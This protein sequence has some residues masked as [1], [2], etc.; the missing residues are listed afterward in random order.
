MHL[1]IAGKMYLDMKG[2]APIFI[3][4]GLS[5]YVEILEIYIGNFE[6]AISALKYL[7]LLLFLVIHLLG[8]SCVFDDIVGV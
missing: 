8:N 5:L 3:R 1:C 4:V 6:F 7:P 2:K